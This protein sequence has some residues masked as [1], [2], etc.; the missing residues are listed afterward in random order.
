MQDG[1]ERRQATTKAVR[2]AAKVRSIGEDGAVDGGQCAAAETGDATAINGGGV[3][4]EGT[5][6]QRRRAKVRQ[7][8]AVAATGRS[9]VQERATTNR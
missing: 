4:C 6:V 9:V 1:V 8:P 5:L 3:A 2:R 7:T